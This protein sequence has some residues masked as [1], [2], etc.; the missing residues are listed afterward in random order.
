MSRAEHLAGKKESQSQYPRIPEQDMGR[1]ELLAEVV[2]EGGKRKGKGGS[3][4]KQQ[5]KFTTEH[6]ALLGVRLVIPSREVPS[7]A[8]LIAR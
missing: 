6:S 4:K 2:L 1:E 3:E 8:W 5:W 7:D